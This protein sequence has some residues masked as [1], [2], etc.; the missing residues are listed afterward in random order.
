MPTPANHAQPAL[1]SAWI[2]VCHRCGH[3]WVEA[4]RCVAFLQ[5]QAPD[6]RPIHE[7]DCRPPLR[8]PRCGALEMSQG[9]SRDSRC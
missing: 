2:C 5:G 8:R 1:A 3:D 6:E 9:Q 4:C 7:G